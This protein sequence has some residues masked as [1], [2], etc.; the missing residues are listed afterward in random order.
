MG[1]SFC[2][3]DV[4]RVKAPWKRSHAKVTD[5]VLTFLKDVKMQNSFAIAHLEYCKETEVVLCC[6]C[7]RYCLGGS[8]PSTAASEDDFPF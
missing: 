5:T 8:L 1:S 6:C 7:T 3:S 4:R 2:F